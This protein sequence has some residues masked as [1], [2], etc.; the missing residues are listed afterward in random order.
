MM[1][2]IYEQ[3]NLVISWLGSAIETDEA[4]FSLIRTIYERFGAPSL[5]DLGS[6]SFAQGDELCLPGIEDP[7]W[8]CVCKIL[9]RPYFFRVWIIQEI[10]SAKTCIV[11]CGTHVVDR[12]VILG[13]GGIVEKFHYLKNM[14]TANAPL[15]DSYH[16]S[17]MV[18]S[19]SVGGLW[20][21]KSLFD[22]SE[23][24]TIL[25]LLQSTRMFKAT[26]P[27]DK[28]FSLV[29]LASNVGIEFIDYDKPLAT[30][31]KEVAEISMQIKESCGPRLL[32]Y[33]D[34]K[35]HA[36]DLPSWVP[37]WT[38]GGP[39]QTALAG[40]FYDLR[41]FRNAE[42]TGFVTT[43]NV[44]PLYSLQAYQILRRS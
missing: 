20:S 43:N 3:A 26:E 9:Y 24:P 33:V 19:Y 29:A 32:S 17:A 34:R 25:Q 2:E 8:A 41:S 14:L 31:Q 6:I 28:V 30:V 23:P 27:R 15:G 11:Q 22:C 5:S 42:K 35:H 18:T 10:L 13:I 16:S 12:D 38:C 44:S 7:V 40:S 1:R 21:L 4:G 37:D 36:D 39:M